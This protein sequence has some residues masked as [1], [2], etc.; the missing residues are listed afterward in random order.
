MPPIPSKR[1]SKW[2]G[3]ALMLLASL[4]GAQAEPVN[5][6]ADA[7]F[8]HIEAYGEMATRMEPVKA[9]MSLAEDRETAS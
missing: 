4:T 8:A 3:I 1:Q 6:K 7:L 2:V 5:E 9:S